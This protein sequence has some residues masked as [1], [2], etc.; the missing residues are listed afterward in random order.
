[1][2]YTE[3]PTQVLGRLERAKDEFNQYMHEVISTAT[4]SSDISNRGDLLSS[5]SKLENKIEAAR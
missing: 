2:A 5:M 3:L 4:G 1:M